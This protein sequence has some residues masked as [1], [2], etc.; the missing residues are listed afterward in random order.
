MGLDGSSYHMWIIS[1]DVVE[2]VNGGSLQEVNVTLFEMLNIV[3]SSVHVWCEVLK[4]LWGPDVGQSFDVQ[5]LL[6]HISCGNKFF[7]RLLE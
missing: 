5:N 4:N 3:G 2:R 6:M 1:D 7:S